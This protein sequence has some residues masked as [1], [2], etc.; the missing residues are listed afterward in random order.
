[1][2][3]GRECVCVWRSQLDGLRVFFCLW[4]MV[5]WLL[6]NKGS[7]AC[8][9]FVYLLLEIKLELDKHDEITHKVANGGAKKLPPNSME[10]QKHPFE[11]IH[12]RKTK[13]K[14]EN[15]TT[16]VLSTPTRPT[17][18][19]THTPISCCVHTLAEQFYNILKITIVAASLSV[20]KYKAGTVQH[21]VLELSL[22]TG[23]LICMS[24]TLTSQH[25][26]S[27]SRAIKSGSH[28]EPLR[29]QAARA[30]DRHSEAYWD[31]M[32][33]F[34]SCSRCQR[35]SRRSMCWAHYNKR[36][37][38]T[39]TVTQKNSLPVRTEAQIRKMSKTSRG[40]REWPRTMWTDLPRG[41]I[42]RAKC[43]R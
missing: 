26:L 18:T 40:V 31:Q 7:C 1:M 37:S 6:S 25:S 9:T 13:Q 17:P 30:I 2:S 28:Y 15:L 39:G 12:S 38:Y 33:H 24:R 22:L 16:S 32:H 27:V 23:T 19:D 42:S 10:E 5:L 14:K 36:W 21:K 34:D 4:A 3:G 11:M 8:R 43:A 29:V 35:R 20:H 41:N